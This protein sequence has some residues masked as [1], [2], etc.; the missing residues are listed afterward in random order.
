MGIRA[1]TV[2]PPHEEPSPTT[3]EQSDKRFHTDTAV[4]QT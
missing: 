3:R 2:A 1:A 4:M